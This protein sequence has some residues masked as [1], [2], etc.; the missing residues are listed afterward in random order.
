[1][2]GGGW[3]SDLQRES[4]DQDKKL[5]SMLNFDKMD[6]VKPICVKIRENTIG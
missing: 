2:R 1:M 6:P 4:T 3:G 5:E